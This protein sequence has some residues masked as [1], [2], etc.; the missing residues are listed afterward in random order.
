MPPTYLF[1]EISFNR[2]QNTIK[3]YPKIALFLDFDGT[4][5]PI[6]KDPAKCFLSDSI[7]KQLKS[8]TDSNHCYTVILSG[9][10]LSDIKKRVGIKKIYYGGNHGLD[11]SG[12]SMRYIHPEAQ[13]AK[14]IINAIE[15]KLKKET[16]KIEGTWLENKKYSL[17]LHFRSVKIQSILSV[18]KIFFKT[19]SRLLD[20]KILTVI[21]GKQILEFIPDVSWDKGKAVLWV[22]NHLKDKCLPIYI[23]DDQTDENAFE[24]L[25]KKGITIRIGKL[26]KT[27]A[28]YYLNGSWEVSRLL[29]K[30]LEL[31]R[32]SL[33]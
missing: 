13:R 10:S 22:L 31:Q 5:V 18:K 32:I 27:S 1:E 20:K 16:S 28:N 33:K 12:P 15:R 4:L 7:R 26:K 21:K 29:K 3:K 30:V 9:R 14:P 6:Q 19:A 17:S 2:F 8:I 24:V 23:G 25:Y 11:I